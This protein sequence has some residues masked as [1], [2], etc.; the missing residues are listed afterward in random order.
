[1]RELI[2]VGGNIYYL[3]KFAGTFGSG[4]TGP[5]TRN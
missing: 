2:A 4:E 5:G 3:A 1:V